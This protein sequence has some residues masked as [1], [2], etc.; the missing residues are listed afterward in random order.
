MSTPKPSPHPLIPLDVRAKALL[1]E[2]SSS[3][4]SVAIF[5]APYDLGSR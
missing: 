1:V 2:T 4:F 5:V 3:A